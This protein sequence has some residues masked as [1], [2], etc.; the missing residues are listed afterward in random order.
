MLDCLNDAIDMGRKVSFQLDHYT[1]R[2]RRAAYRHGET[3]VVSPYALVWDG[4][5]YYLIGHCDNRNH[6]R[7]FRVDRIRSRPALLNEKSVPE[8]AGFSVAEYARRVFRMFGSE[9]PVDVELLCDA[10]MMNHIVDRFGTKANTAIVDDGH[11]TATVNVCPSKTFFGWVFGFAGKIR[12]TGP[13]DVR[14][15]YQNMVKNAL[16]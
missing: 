12:I 16:K 2:K 14:S 10:D 4:G 9:D 11:F 6:I 5:N 3:Y 7:Y 8:P 13:E 1:M 15:E